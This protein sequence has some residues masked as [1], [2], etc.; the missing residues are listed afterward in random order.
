M[1]WPTRLHVFPSERAPKGGD[2]RDA[3]GISGE[4]IMN[5]V[6]HEEGVLG[7]TV[8]PVERYPYGFGVGLVSG[9]RVRADDRIHVSGEPNMSE[10]AH[11]EV[12]GLAGDDADLV[13]VRA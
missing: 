6:A 12:L 4:H 10:T 3:G 7:R 9:R 5:G 11:R 8:E 13:A 2:G 1:G